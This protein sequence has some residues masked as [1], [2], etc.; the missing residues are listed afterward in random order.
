MDAAKNFAKGTLTTGYDDT[1]TS[2]VLNAGDGARFPAVPFNAVWWNATD[3]PDP[4]DDQFAE[5]V[6]VT[7]KSTDTLTISRGQEGTGDPG[8]SG[9]S[10]NSE[11][12]VYKL[13]APLTAKAINDEMLPVARTGGDYSIDITET[14]DIDAGESLLLSGVTSARVE[15]LTPGMVMIIGGT[16]AALGDVD[17]NNS[18]AALIVDDADGTVGLRGKFAKDGTASATTLGTVTKKLEIFALDG[19]SLGFIPIYNSIT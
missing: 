6:R 8:V 4:A 16:V 10:H 13:I 11:G 7:A 19:T 14:L 15:A 2:I 18:N 3:F 1:V 9:H 5:I 12:K 17:G